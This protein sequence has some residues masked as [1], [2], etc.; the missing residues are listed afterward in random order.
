MRSLHP[1]EAQGA[2]LEITLLLPPSVNGAYANAPGRGRFKTPEFRKWE[3]A[4]L[5]ECYLVQRGKVK[6]GYRL[7][8]VLPSNMRGDIDNRIKPTQDLLV[9]GGVLPDDRHAAAVSAE[10]GVHREPVVHCII[11]WSEDQC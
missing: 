8:L 10:R 1:S 5:P 2:R 7:H 6:P 11:T 4:A 3:R 9:K